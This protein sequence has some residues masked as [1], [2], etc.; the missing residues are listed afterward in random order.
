M[1]VKNHIGFVFLLITALQLNTMAAKRYWIGSVDKN[2]NTTSPTTNWA[3]TSGGAVNASVP[4]TNDTA[5]FDNGTGKRCNLDINI[6]VK[7]LEFKSTSAD[8][9]DQNSHTITIGTS[10]YVDR[11]STRLN[12]R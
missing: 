7:R 11:K 3:A 12:S 5:Y 4:G 8:T 9:L 6:S 1:K 10:G 2:W